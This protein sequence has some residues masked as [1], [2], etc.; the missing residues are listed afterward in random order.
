[1]AGNGGF[2]SAINGFDK[3]E[4]NEYIGNLRKR[5]QEMEADIRSNEEKTRAAVKTAEEADSRIAEL[6]KK[7]AERVS[8][9]EAQ[10]KTERRNAD[11]LQNENDELKRKLR[12][13]SSAS[14]SGGGSGASAASVAEA[15]KRAAE[16][17][18]KANA[19]AKEIV[20]KAKAA[21]QQIMSGAGKSGGGV[22]AKSAE[23]FGAILRE[24]TKSVTDALNAASRKASEMS[25]GAGGAGGAVSAP[26]S[27]LD[28]SAFEAP[29]AE[30]PAPAAAAPKPAPEVKPAES[31]SMDDLFS[32]MADDSDMSDMGDFGEIKPLDPLKPNHEVVE[33]FDLS[34]VGKFNEEG[35]VTEVA[36]IDKKS[37]GAVIDEDFTAELLTQTVPS[38]ALKDQ[39]DEDLFAAVKEREEQF[40]V[41]P[42][43]DKKDFDM[44]DAAGGLDAMNALLGQM[45]AALESAGGNASLDLDA[46]EPAA[47]DN[48]ASDNPWADLQNQLNAMEESGNFGGG[49]DGSASAPEAP[50]D[51]PKAPDAD[52]SSIW[53]F[54]SDMGSDTADDDMSSDLFGN[55]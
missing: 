17:I 50:A 28:L 11:N 10:V 52:D 20:E 40:A 39:I 13:A 53:N 19:Q 48:S 18:E 7:N 54:D 37:G 5:L 36:P 51:D 27:E 23:E 25:G 49:D 8:E 6:E 30:V 38:S 35:A 34:D 41:Q 55:F 14:Q 3:N 45:G 32:N 12:H 33:G 15:E 1:M 42:S 2:K 47:A 21:A 44:D 43:D 29:Q 4:V 22:S 26:V 9:L 31:V 16:T 24:L 46:S